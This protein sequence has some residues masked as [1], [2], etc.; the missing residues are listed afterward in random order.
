MCS[1]DGDL[2]ITS[3]SS[4]S[5]ASSAGYAHRPRQAPGGFRGSP[6]SRD[7]R[8]GPAPARGPVAPAGDGARGR[9]RVYRAPRV[10]SAG[11]PTYTI[12]RTPST[13]GTSELPRVRP[14]RLPR[15]GER[16][17][18]GSA[19]EDDDLLRL[20][21]NR[22]RGARRRR[23]HSAEAAFQLPIRF[24]R[25]SVARWPTRSAT[26]RRAPSARS[27]IMCRRFPTSAYTARK[28]GAALSV[29]DA[30]SRRRGWCVAFAPRH[31]SRC[32]TA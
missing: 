15:R 12:A 3:T 14:P 25:R 16:A 30:P 31:Y 28:T 8:S 9:G 18:S 4:P 5:R 27:G 22:T 19:R 6:D 1:L 32:R 20:V 2:A 26:G 13:R 7:P 11:T 24:N 10:S 21:S 17:H 23:R 29:R